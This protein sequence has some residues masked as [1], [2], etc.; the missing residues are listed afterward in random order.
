MS[1]TSETPVAERQI[2][3]VG[4]YGSLVRVLSAPSQRTQDGESPRLHADPRQPIGLRPL[5]LT[6][7]SI[8]W[9]ARARQRHFRLLKR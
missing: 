9:T 1:A 3:I 2:L 8:S 4:P 5:P 6:S 7:A